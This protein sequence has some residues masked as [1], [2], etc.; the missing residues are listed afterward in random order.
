[1]PSLAEESNPKS[2]QRLESR[3]DTID[4]RYLGAQG[5]LGNRIELVNILLG[6]AC[7][8]WETS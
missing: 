7:P 4:H 5:Y 1:M 3:G 6:S 8:N 2:E